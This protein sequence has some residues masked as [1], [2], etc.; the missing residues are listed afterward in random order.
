MK[1]VLGRSDLFEHQ[2]LSRGTEKHLQRTC[3]KEPE[4]SWKLTELTRSAPQKYLLGISYLVQTGSKPT[5]SIV[6]H[7]GK[8]TIKKKV[9]RKK[10]YYIVKITKR[11]ENMK[12]FLQEKGQNFYRIKKKRN[13]VG[14]GLQKERTSS[15]SR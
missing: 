15:K 1:L 9:E 3:C 12:E 8:K 11:V 7:L 6:H 14:S 5:Q 4:L 2:E 10:R 13:H